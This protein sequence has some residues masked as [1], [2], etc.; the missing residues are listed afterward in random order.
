M[1]AS[2]PGDGMDAPTERITVCGTPDGTEMRADDPRWAAAAERRT[3]P[4]W[5]DRVG[6]RVVAVTH[7]PDCI[8]FRLNPLHWLTCGVR[9]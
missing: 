5:R 8:R 6:E 4:R 3:R 2:T 7:C 1:T 9:R